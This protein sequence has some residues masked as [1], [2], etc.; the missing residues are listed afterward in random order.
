MGVKSPKLSCRDHYRMS[1]RLYR[2]AAH[3]CVH[4]VRPVWRS[5]VKM[6]VNSTPPF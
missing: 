6:L 3:C 1:H 5:L 2:G 4:A